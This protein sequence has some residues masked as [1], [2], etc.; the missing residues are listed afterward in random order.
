MASCPTVNIKYQAFRHPFT[1]MCVG[2]TMAGKTNY[3]LRLI[4]HKDSAI[5]PNVKRVIYSYKKYQ[6]VFDT[7]P[8]VEFVQGANY[9]LDRS[10]PTLLI[11]DDQ[12]NDGSVELTDLFTV[13]AHHDNCST[14]FVSQVLFLQDRAYRNACQNAMYM[15]LF[16]SPRSKTQIGHLARQMFVGKKANNMIRA[17]E[18]ATSQP[19]ANLIVDCRPDTPEN[20]RLKTNI[21]PDEGQKFRGVKLGHVYII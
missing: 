4:Q 2:P 11:I 3:L 8:G 12:M 21:L 14:I 6:S 7:V 10:V 19:F 18:D 16:R 9:V 17:F 20:M 1:C 5:Q 15:I 13:G